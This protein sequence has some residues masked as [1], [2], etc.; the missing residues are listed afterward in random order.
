MKKKKK[1]L[2][3]RIESKKRSI[4]KV[5]KKKSLTPSQYAR[6]SNTTN[7]RRASTISNTQIASDQIKQQSIFNPVRQSNGTEIINGE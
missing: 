3:Q 5:N 7:N 6:K 4:S 2:K 1:L